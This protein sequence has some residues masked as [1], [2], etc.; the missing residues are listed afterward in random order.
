MNNSNKKKQPLKDAEL[1]PVNKEE[2][3]R[4]SGYT[5]TETEERTD[6]SVPLKEVE[7]EEIVP[8][9]DLGQKNRP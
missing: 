8:L 6:I 2:T 5:Y 4:G 3:M 9:P 1:L 7:G